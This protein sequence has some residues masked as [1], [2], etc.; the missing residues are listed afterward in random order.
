MAQEKKISSKE[1]KRNMRNDVAQKLAKA[2]ESYKADLGEK[3]FK[4]RIAKAGKVFLKNAST[5]A[6]KVSS[7]EKVKTATPK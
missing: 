4:K 6:T 7:S 5:P 1:V 2:L 3:K